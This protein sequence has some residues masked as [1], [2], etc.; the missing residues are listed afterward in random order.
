MFTSKAPSLL[1]K[2]AK[3]EK[4]STSLART[5]KTIYFIQTIKTFVFILA[6][7]ILKNFKKSTTLFDTGYH[8]LGACLYE[9][10]LEGFVVVLN[11]KQ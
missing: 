8:A 11:C 3:L 2:D 9:N 5:K 1:R 6:V 4:Q 10:R 7:S